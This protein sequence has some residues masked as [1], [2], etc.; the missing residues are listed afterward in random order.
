MAK[1]LGLIVKLAWPAALV[2]VGAGALVAGLRA[3]RS[4]VAA[5][6][7]RTRLGEVAGEYNTLREQYNS[8]VARTAVT[9][10]LVEDGKLSVR[11]RTAAGAEKVIPAPF[12]PRGEIYVDYAVVDG[13]LWIRR[14]FDARTAPAE[15]LV[16]DP[17]LAELDFAAPGVR[18]GKAVYRTLGEGRWVISVTGDGSL[19]L[20]H[21][22]SAAPAP[23]TPAPEVREFDEIDEEAKREADQV[24]VL[25][26]LKALFGG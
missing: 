14:V 22:G 18:V 12:D 8:A 11:V 4:D 5:E 15:G 3:V 23:L 19:G 6:V 1:P 26:A 10:L 20:T 2:V 25:D 21:A 16:I 13:R 9:E 24:G 17:A 7:Y